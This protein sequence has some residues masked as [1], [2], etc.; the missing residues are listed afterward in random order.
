M[1]QVNGKNEYRVDTKSLT[2]KT[3]DLGQLQIATADLNS[4][5]ANY[6]W[7][8]TARTIERRFAHLGF[9]NIWA[10]PQRE[11]AYDLVKVYT[12]T[13]RPVYRP[14]TPVQFKFWMARARY[15]QDEKLGV[16]RQIV[17]G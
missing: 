15:D 5:Q 7:L 2:T 13:D 11:A 6:Q 1:V 8:I 16:C 9:T 14:G 10:F 4:V 12:I 3:D 17:Q